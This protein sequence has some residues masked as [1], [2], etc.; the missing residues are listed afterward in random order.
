MALVLCSAGASMAQSRPATAPA[1][2]YTAS[3]EPTAAVERVDKKMESTRR[4]QRTLGQRQSRA[5]GALNAKPAGRIPGRIAN[6][7]QNRL[8]TRIE[9]AS[10]GRG[11]TP[12]TPEAIRQAATRSTRVAPPRSP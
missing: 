5:D 12:Q 8:S 11:E 10:Y 7:V 4:A 9:P 3:T 1:N 2:P 6:R